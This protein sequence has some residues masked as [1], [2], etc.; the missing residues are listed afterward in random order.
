M[1]NR[2]NPE[3]LATRFWRKVRKTS[4]CWW[5]L[6]ATTKQGYGHIIRGGGQRNGYIQAHRAAW[7]LLV[8]PIP[9]GLCLCHHCDNKHCVRPEHLFL[10]T[11]KD[12]KQDYAKKRLGYSRGRYF[13]ARLRA[14]QVRVIKRTRT[15]TAVLSQRFG[16]SQRYIRTLRQDKGWVWISGA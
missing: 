3:P 6:G 13:N 7:E 11:K 10:G 4:D 15:S 2:Y 1:A 5:W 8:G 12:N 14:W 16:V 9:D